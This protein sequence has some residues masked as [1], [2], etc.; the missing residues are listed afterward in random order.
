MKIIYHHRT[1]AT[2]AEGV[3][4]ASIIKGFRDMGHE[5]EV[6]SPSAVD[7]LMSAGSS[8][9]EKKEGLKSTVFRFLSRSLPQFLFEI[10][11]LS[12]NAVAYF[13]LSKALMKQKVAFIYERYAFFSFMGAYLAAKNCIPLIIEVN[14]IAGEQR[15]RKQVFVGWARKIE[16]YIFKKADLIMVVSQ[17]L[18][19]KIIGLGVN[20]EKIIVLP[21][22]VDPQRFSLSVSSNGLRERYSIADGVLVFGFIGWFVAWHNLELLV[23]AFAAVAEKSNNVRLVLVGD[24]VLK[25]ELQKQARIKGV[26]EKVIFTGS[27]S[28]KDIP[29][30]I[31]LMDICVI[32]ATNEYRSPIKMFEYMAM[33]KAVVAPKL[34]PIEDVLED[35]HDAMFF[36]PDDFSTLTEVFK[37]LIQDAQMRSLLGRRARQKIEKEYTWENNA[38]KILKLAEG[39]AG[40]KDKVEQ[41]C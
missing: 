13:K 14:E 23:D 15:V 7:P 19:D 22:A 4:I 35:G 26:E 3:H 31:G 24:G 33:A 11:E 39:L 2:G 9:Y 40:D 16:G 10:V 34:K 32:P 30:Y 37:K 20:G 38:R 8:P 36:E 29:Q 17:F 12:Y 6:V 21:N 41:V 27:V 5:V 28:H 25:E 1:Q 18:K